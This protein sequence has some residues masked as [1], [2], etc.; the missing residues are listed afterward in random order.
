MGALRDAI[1]LVPGARIAKQGEHL[2]VLIKGLRNTAESVR[3]G[4]ASPALL[5]G[6]K[7]VRL[8][9]TVIATGETRQ[10]DLF[11][12]YMSDLVP[13]LSQQSPRIKLWEGTKVLLFWFTSGM[14]RALR[15][16][17]YLVLSAIVS[18]IGFLLWYFSVLALGLT[19]LGELKPPEGSGLLP[20]AVALA[21]AS[22]KR[23][24]SWVVWLGLTTLLGL[25]RADRLADIG[26][27]LR[28]YLT[29][30]ELRSDFRNRLRE[31]LYQIVDSGEYRQVTVLAHSFGSLVAADVLAEF[32]PKA[33]PSVGV[34]TLG[35]PIAV[36]LG[37]AAWLP[38]ELKRCSENATL[39]FWVDFS[40]RSD[41]MGAPVSFEREPVFSFVPIALLDMGGFVD[42]FTG[43][44][45]RAYFHRS[46]VT[47]CLVTPETIWAKP[48]DAPPRAA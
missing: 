20:Q 3:F 25:S 38:K 43:G 23:L 29:C 17:P 13:N 4:E 45:H 7:G 24:G 42:Q 30:D 35:S 46:E 34:I 33:G 21:A 15:Q 9:C 10:V 32:K 16:H 44:A 1:V 27:F 26:H 5:A 18:S 31:P 37:M 36:L 6:L 12:C 39:R 19:A 2:E 40:S 14:W 22:G 8:A 48:K 28:R 11:E 41:W 47:E